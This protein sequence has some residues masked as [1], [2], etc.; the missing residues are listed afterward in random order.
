MYPRPQIKID[1]SAIKK[2][3]VT[4]VDEEEE[5]SERETFRSWRR[6]RF[7]ERDVT[8]GLHLQL[9]NYRNAEMG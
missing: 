7:K 8:V 3:I 5:E 9:H 4:E 6:V 2:A 1:L